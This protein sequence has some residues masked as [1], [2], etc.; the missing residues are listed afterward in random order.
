[1]TKTLL[2]ALVP[3]FHC[4]PEVV[5]STAC[6]LKLQCAAGAALVLGLHRGRIVFHDVSPSPALLRNCCLHH[7]S[8]PVDSGTLSSAASRNMLRSCHRPGTELYSRA[9]LAP[10]ALPGIKPSDALC[11]RQCW[12]PCRGRHMIIP[13]QFKLAQW[14]DSPAGTPGNTGPG[15]TLAQTAT[16]PSLEQ[17]RKTLQSGQGPSVG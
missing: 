11:S 8:R 5:G 7:W 13:L 9:T 10:P 2:K 6:L 1:M 14:Q 12:L 17:V 16:A 15:N 4:S 3:V